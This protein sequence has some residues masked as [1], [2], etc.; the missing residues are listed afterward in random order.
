MAKY[1]FIPVA[2][3]T[4]VAAAMIFQTS[5]NEQAVPQMFDRNACYSNCPCGIV[6]AE[7]LC[8]DCK[9]KCDEKFWD[10][11]DKEEQQAEN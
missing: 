3:V 11:F 6:G 7:Q 4:L 1:L 9:E 8:L 10:E 2:V 5:A